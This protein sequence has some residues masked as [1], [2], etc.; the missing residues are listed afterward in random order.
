MSSVGERGYAD[1]LVSLGILLSLS[2]TVVAWRSSRTG[3]AR[4]LLTLG[5]ALGG[6]ALI[7]RSMQSGQGPFSNPFMALAVLGLTVGLWSIS[8]LPLDYR[9]YMLGGLATGLALGLYLLV[10]GKALLSAPS[11]S[12]LLSLAEIAYVLATGA[13]LY[14]TLELAIC[15]FQVSMAMVR[16]IM[17]IAL[18]LQ[19]ATLIL[20]G[21][22]A[23]FAWGAY[24]SWD[25]VECWR[26]IAWLVTAIATLGIGR[27]DWGR[28][29]GMVAIC[30]AA[31]MAL[32]VLLG[33]F[34]L[35][36]WLNLS[37]VYLAE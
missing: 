25:A 22:S 18:L 14:G 13:L 15:G 8:L 24:W 26:L 2:A 10:P 27:L 37:S 20:Q 32:L 21:V 36:Q 7:A 4:A 19:T 5:C 33:S 11:G 29:R 16:A 9:S 23:Q 1:L 35:V 3:M 31:G 12:L 17:G 6:W 28:R 30:L 34:P